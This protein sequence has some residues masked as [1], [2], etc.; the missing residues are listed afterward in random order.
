[1]GIDRGR[2]T[3]LYRTLEK[4]G[5][6]ERPQ[7]S[8]W[9]H[10]RLTEWGQ[11]AIA[12]GIEMINYTRKMKPKIATGNEPMYPSKVRPSEPNMLKYGTNYK[13][14]RT[15]R[16]GP[17]RGASIYTLTLPERTTCPVSCEL[18][19]PCYGNNMPRSIRYMVDDNFYGHLERQLD[20]ICKPGRL[21]LIRLHVLGD[22][23]PVI[24]YAW[25]WEK[26]LGRWPNL[27]IFGF[28][29]HPRRSMTGVAIARI[30]SEFGWLRAA[31]RFS[32]GKMA[33]HT[34]DLCDDN[35]LAIPCPFETGLVDDCGSC[36]LCWHSERS[37]GWKL[38]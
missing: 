10:G 9:R 25:F 29:A 26:M 17:L 15:V 31:I 27:H 30:T 36:G 13:I 7:G 24:T 21:I 14:G 28:T 37:I 33:L 3:A 1:M 5:Y 11:D 38:H 22:F 12:N 20:S 6:I 23:I 35:P 16:K 2:T 34:A 4:K 32:G 18:W 8:R 19:G